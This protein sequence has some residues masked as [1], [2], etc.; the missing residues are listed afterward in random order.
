MTIKVVI[1]KYCKKVIKRP[2]RRQNYHKLCHKKYRKEYKRDK[3]R[4]YYKRK[5]AH[6]KNKLCI[7]CKKPF[8][9]DHGNQLYC[10]FCKINLNSILKGFKS[11]E[12][13][14]SFKKK[15]CV[16]CSSKLI[17][18]HHEDTFKCLQCD[19]KRRSPTPVKEKSYPRIN[20]FTYY[21]D[22][23][24]DPNFQA[25]RGKNQNQYSSSIAP[26]SGKLSYNLNSLNEAF[27]EDC[28]MLKE[29]CTCEHTV[30]KIP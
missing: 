20:L 24:Y 1:C 29:R 14:R 26:E 9:A 4:E 8:V 25:I 13:E 28:G 11:L 15:E 21:S 7:F 2:K 18:V 16:N 10:I 22:F 27:C 19:Y 17:Y 12:E 23:P 6:K 5:N 3:E 30:Q